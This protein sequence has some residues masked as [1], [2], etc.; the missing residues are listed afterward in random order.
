MIAP[1]CKDHGAYFRLVE[2]NSNAVGLWRM[3]SRGVRGI[4]SGRLKMHPNI[5]DTVCYFISNQVNLY[6]RNSTVSSVRKGKQGK[7]HELWFDASLN[8]IY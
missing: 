3:R 7:G 1:C 8:R 6:E 4:L 5:P 2:A